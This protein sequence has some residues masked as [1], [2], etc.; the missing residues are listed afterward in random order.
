MNLNRS[1]L[2][3]IILILSLTVYVVSASAAK[4]TDWVRQKADFRISG[5]SR[6]K[7]IYHPKD[8]PVSTRALKR[9]QDK[10]TQPQTIIT[11]VQAPAVIRL[12]VIDSPPIDGFVPW[13]AVTT[14]DEKGE[15]LDLVA[16]PESS[17][18]GIST[19]SSPPDYVIGILDT[20]ASAHVMGYEAANTLNLF[21][22]GPDGLVTNNEIQITGVT[23]SVITSVS[24][25]LGIFIDSLS[26][27]SGMG[28]LNT[29][30]MVGESNVSIIVGQQPLG[31]APDLP[32]AIGSPMSVFYSTVFDVENPITIVHDNNDFT[33]PVIGIYEHGDPCIPRYFNVLPLE[34]RPLGGVSVQ[35]TPDFD[36]FD[37]DLENLGDWSFETPGTPSII[38]GNLSQSIFFVHSVDLSEGSNTASDKS[39]FMLDTG[40]QVS[41]IGKRMGARLG[42]DESM[43]DFTVEVT[44]VT[45]IPSTVKGFHI[46]SVVIPCLGQWL[47]FTDVPMILLDIY[48][49]EGGTLDG[50]IGMNLFVEYNFV[51][52]G[53]GMFLQEDPAILF[54]HKDH[55][56]ADVAPGGGDGIVNVVDVIAMAR[57][58]LTTP[59]DLQWNPRCDIA[60]SP[61][62]DGIIN[63][64]D[65]AVI[66]NH[67]L[68]TE[69]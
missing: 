56:I 21:G 30:G 38:I 1:I 7:A 44:G 18:V 64:A 43:P 2:A 32:T 42:L 15:E 60:P 22:Y 4:K 3:G 54:E 68:E 11:D 65:F 48:S 6:V 33:S 36:F 55:I 62:P 45:G 59:G 61:R 57:S 31:N 49:P 25:P 28:T 27:I 10:A 58:W 29:S 66:A 35:Y 69:N 41:V 9:K 12:N 50:I 52:K 19:S 20:G 17:I 8:K 14:T 67:W 63:Q 53:G 47:R 5:N 16:E 23:G 26:A 39:R 24:Y 46:D 40:A 34:L 37:L 13:I 51:L